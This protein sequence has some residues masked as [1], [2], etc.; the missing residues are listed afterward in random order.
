LKIKI[1]IDEK[2][3]IKKLEEYLYR[4]LRKKLREYCEYE[5]DLLVQLDKNEITVKH[6][7]IERRLERIEDWIKDRD[8]GFKIFRN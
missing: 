7:E 6:P 1:E 2:E 4:R 5:E 8:R 3:I